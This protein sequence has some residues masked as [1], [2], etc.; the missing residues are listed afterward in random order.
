MSDQINNRMFHENLSLN[1]FLETFFCLH[2]HLFKEFTQHYPL[3]KVVNLPYKKMQNYI[4]HFCFFHIRKTYNL[5]DL[6][7]LL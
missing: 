7:A 3:Y 2:N 1:L 4:D 5:N 6:S